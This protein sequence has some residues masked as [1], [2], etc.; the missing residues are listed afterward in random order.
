MLLIALLPFIVLPLSATSTKIA[1]QLLLFVK[2]GAEQINA[3]EIGGLSAYSH[4]LFMT[5]HDTGGPCGNITFTN[6][7][8]QTW[9]WE[10]DIMT[11]MADEKE[12]RN[13]EMHGIVSCYPENS[14]GE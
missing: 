1:S 11:G 4:E 13:L 12:V 8:G 9:E 14:R 2:E 3:A 7:K 10:W 5:G 6:R